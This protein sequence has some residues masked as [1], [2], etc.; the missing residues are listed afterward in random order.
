MKQL[1]VAEG[2]QSVV[3][4]APFVVCGSSGSTQSVIFCC[5]VALLSDDAASSSKNIVMGDLQL[6]FTEFK[7][8]SY[9]P[10]MKLIEVVLIHVI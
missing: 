8:C 7:I 5:C 6:Q 9:M 10:K 2:G 4:C 3:K 1:Q